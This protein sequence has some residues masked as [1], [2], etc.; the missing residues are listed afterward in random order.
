MFKIFKKKIIASYETK[1]VDALEVWSVRWESHKGQYSA[2]IE[3][4]AEFFVTE[5]SAELFAKSI[6]AARELIRYTS[7]RAPVIKKEPITKG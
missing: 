7:G 1:E 6:N 5:E 2:D 3:T 4:Y